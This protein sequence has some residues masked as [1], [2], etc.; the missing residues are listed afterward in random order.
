MNRVPPAPLARIAVSLLLGLAVIAESREESQQPENKEP[1]APT[2]VRKIEKD[3]FERTKHPI[4]Q[5]DLD[6]IM[7][8][9]DFSGTAPSEVSWAGD[10]SR[11]WFRWKKP[12]EKEPGIF[13]VPRTGG[14][15]RRLTKDEEAAAPPSAADRDLAGRWA[16]YAFEG[17]I[18][19]L[20]THSGKFRKITETPE[21]ESD[22][23]F[24]G[25]EKKIVFRRGDNLF[26]ISLAGESSLR[27]LTDIRPGKDPEL[28]KE[29][30]EKEGQRRFLKDQQEELFAVLEKKARKQKEE[31]ERKKASRPQPLFIGDK[32]VERLSLS[33]DEQFAAVE[34]AEEPK[35]QQVPRVPDYVTLSGFTAELKARVKVGDLPKRYA[36]TLLNLATSQ[37]IELKLP[38]SEPSQQ[39]SDPQPDDDA[40]KEKSPDVFNPVWSKKGHRLLV[41]MRAPN[42]KDQWL[43]GIDAETSETRILN[44]EH[45]DAWVLNDD[46]APSL[47]LLESGFLEES[48]QV[49]FLSE[50]T[51]FRH[52]YKMPW[53]GGPAKAQTEGKFEVWNTRLSKDEGTFYFQ[54][55]QDGPEVMQFYALAAAGGAPQK[56][57]SEIGNHQVTLSPDE[58]FLA[59]VYSFSNKPWELYVQPRQAPGQRLAL[60]DSP[61]A[62]FKTYSWIEPKL[63]KVRAR[64]GV[65][66]P[67]RLYVPPKPHLSKPAVIFVHGAGYLQ[68]VHRWWSEYFREYMFHHFLLEHGYTILDLDYRGS[69]GYGRNWRTAIYRHMGGKDLTD[70]IDAADYLIKQHGAK[71]ERIGIYGGSYGGFVTL[72]ALFT[73]PKSFGAG[74]ALR[75]VADW[76]HYNHPY[77][78]NILNQPQEDEEAFRRSSPIYFAEGL[79]DPLLICHGIVDVNVHVQDTIRLA[80]RLIELRK[81]NFEL[82]LYPVEDHAFKEASSWADAYKRIFRLF[83][84]SLKSR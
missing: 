31:E 26:L 68:N 6:L 73:A 84:Q 66:V 27:Q 81:P 55:N 70:Q 64:D 3:L 53:D 7:L 61:A 22:P 44:H 23:A 57:T 1:R 39:P 79:E 18:Y 43:A 2:Q 49:W 13:E 54:S 83:E 17:D 12:G 20:D 76:A 15:P 52:L 46:D 4:K 10:N 24:T 50:R 34:L 11:L 32:K 56:L 28:E 36:L 8:G 29:K 82:M 65:D 71:A 40:R 67:A 47:S 38:N 21:S 16:V 41:T 59:D 75:P 51:G 69:A 35:D 78:S 58:S 19:L 42:N 72:M 5:L 33:A 25:D 77:T 60:T 62:A 74:A 30:K 80:Q 14:A 9:P 45:D 37:A 48:R 63:I